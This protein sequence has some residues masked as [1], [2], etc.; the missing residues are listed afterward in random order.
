MKQ[1]I[2]AASSQAVRLIEQFSHQQ[3]EALALLAGQIG[4][5]FA[6]GGQL[7]IAGQGALQPLAQLLASHFTYRLGFDRP[8]LPAVALG[9]DPVLA[10]AMNGAEQHEQLLGRHY[11]ALC[12]RQ[13]QLL[14]LLSDGGAQRS[15]RLLLDDVLEN[16]QPVALLTPDRQ[17]DPLC[18]SGVE[19]CIILETHNTA[20]LLELSLFA[21]NLLCELVEAE[22]FGI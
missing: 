12:G 22:L 21:A 11:R 5:L 7:L 19:N 8:V 9:S 16:G 2:T 14:L 4:S 13:Q 6:A 18:R 20:R 17:S 3:G 15:L 1:R 10:A